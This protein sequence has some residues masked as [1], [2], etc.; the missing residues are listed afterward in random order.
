[1]KDI[2]QCSVLLPSG[3]NPTAISL[4]TSF[5][6][7]VKQLKQKDPN[8]AAT[9]IWGDTNRLDIR[10]EK[11]CSNH[12]EQ[13]RVTQQDVTIAWQIA[14]DMNVRQLINS[15]H[16]VNSH[17][18]G[19]YDGKEFSSVT[20]AYE[21]A[22]FSVK[23]RERLVVPHKPLRK[24]GDKLLLIDGSNILSRAYYATT[25]KGEAQL[26]RGSS[27][28]YTNAVYVMTQ[29]F[30]NLLREHQPTHVAVC[31]DIDRQ[32]FRRE[33]YPGYKANRDEYP[34][35]LREQFGTM[36]KL[37][38]R[39]GIKVFG[40]KGYEADDLI[41]TIAS[42][43][44]EASSGPCLIV[45]SDKDLYQLLSL[46]VTIIKP[47]RR[48]NSDYLYN[49]AKFEDEYGISTRQ[50]VDVK[51]ILGESGPTGDGI[52]GIKGC[53]IKT[54]IPLIQQFG[55]LEG[56][57]ESLDKLPKELC[58]YAKMLVQGKDN[59]FLSRQLAR[60]VTD[61]PNLSELSVSDLV[62]QIN[63]KSMKHDFKTL[64]LNKLLHDIDGVA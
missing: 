55:N 32:T 30:L 61:V 38:H 5:S 35:A 39:M 64:G 45:S 57:Y 43:W 29:Q 25:K 9:V 4:I 37:L 3:A 22:V 8:A 54:A 1:M 41:G 12:I 11:T 53:G 40:V 48:D 2:E 44:Q 15:I 63:E 50:W 26:R 10:I 31:W 27:G 59:A 14:P 21:G 18:Y 56:V 20:F 6:S 33:L 47:G 52:P 34:L 24:P 16:Q 13:E 7:L 60:I 19:W 23:K 42:R 58:R 17:L 36:Q 28:L 62:L 46:D 51:A 49:L